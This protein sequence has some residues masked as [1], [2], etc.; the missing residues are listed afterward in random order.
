MLGMTNPPIQVLETFTLIVWEYVCMRDQ[1]C[2]VHLVFVPNSTLTTEDLAVLRAAHGYYKDPKCTDM[3]PENRAAVTC[4]AAALS[5]EDS[6]LPEE[7]PKGS[8]WSMRFVPFIAPSS[9]TTYGTPIEGRITTRL[10]Q[11]GIV[12]Y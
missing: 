7:H 1:V 10:L 6:D 11:M 5:E 12:V 9:Y 4:V 8:P 3:P 2:G